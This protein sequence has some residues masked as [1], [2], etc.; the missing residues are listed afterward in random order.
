LLNP[1]AALEIVLSSVSR[2]ETERAALRDC[3][4][5]VLAE[6]VRADED[7]PPFD[8]S[9]MDGF[10]VIADDTQG[11]AR[12]NPRRLEVVAE[13]PA[14][15]MTTQAVTPGAA[16]RIMT[17]ASMPRGADAVVV[18]EDTDSQAGDVV[19]YREVSRGANVR[20]AGEDVKRDQVVLR[21]GTRIGPAQMGMLASVGMT[22]VQVFRKPRV[23]IITTGDELVDASERPGPG[24]IRNGNQYS[25]LGQTL[26][27]GAEVSLLERVGDDKEQIERALSRAAAGSDLV[28]VCGGVS[29]GDYDYVRDVLAKLGEIRFWK[30]AI[31]PGRPLVFGHIKDRPVFGVPGNPVSCMVTFDLFVRPALRRMMGDESEC[32]KVVRGGVTEDLRHK[33]GLR[34]F[35]RAVT[36]Y[37]LPTQGRAGEGS[38]GVYTARPIPKRGSGMLSSM[39]EANSYIVLSE[40]TGDVPCGDTVEIIL[41][42]DV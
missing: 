38:E 28:I 29:V 24:Q 35:V 2:L 4:G 20:R 23:A 27:A 36:T 40:E 41:F 17:G 8:N 19:I 7:I 37:S 10:A 9:A 34:E 42:A 22:E 25:L 16:I 33:P 39:V 12:D 21:E 14:G 3:L 1:D 18:V 6:D 32:H 30:V 31:K 13:Q 5:R 15:K 11:A 26:L